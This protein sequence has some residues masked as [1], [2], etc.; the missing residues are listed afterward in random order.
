VAP[1][2]S[3]FEVAS[4]GDYFDWVQGS[5]LP[6]A[7]QFSDYNGQAAT[8]ADDL[9]F[10]YYSKVIGGVQIVQTAGEIRGQC[11]YN[12]TFSD[13]IQDCFPPDRAP[14]SARSGFSQEGFDQYYRT[15]H[16]ISAGALGN[17]SSNG[18]VTLASDEPS[19]TILFTDVSP[20]ANA[21]VLSYYR[22]GEWLGPQTKELTAH[23]SVYN[24]EWGVYSVL[25]MKHT[26]ERGGFVRPSFVLHT[27]RAK[28]HEVLTERL[29]REREGA[30]DS[31]PTRF[32]V[33]I[34]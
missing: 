11:A 7:L 19:S 20:T 18:G 30:S 6:S 28:P 4:A 3:F 23:V 25:Q 10:Q 24:R 21:H 1:E 27:F 5:L 22:G 32:E 2:G 16:N 12:P 8:S 29:E 31:I 33:L 17:S 34:E 15:A 13:V 14:V 26:F 9:R